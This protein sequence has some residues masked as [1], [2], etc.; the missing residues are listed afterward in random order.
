MVGMYWSSCRLFM[1]NRI[2]TYFFEFDD[3]FLSVLLDGLD[4]YGGALKHFALPVSDEM[5]AEKS[6]KRYGVWC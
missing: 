4:L 3:N 5:V 2:F 1:A 6:L